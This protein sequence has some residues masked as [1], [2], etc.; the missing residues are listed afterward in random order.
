MTNTLHRFG[1][2]AD[3][4]DDY[5]IFTGF[6]TDIPELTSIFDIA[7]LASFFE[8]LGRVLLEAMVLGKPVIATRVGGIVD[9]VDDGNPTHGFPHLRSWS[10]PASAVAGSPPPHLVRDVADPHEPSGTLERLRDPTRRATGLRRADDAVER[11]P[12][13]V[14]YR[15][16]PYAP[17]LPARIP[18]AIRCAPTIW[19]ATG[20]SGIRPRTSISW[21]TRSAGKDIIFAFHPEMWAALAV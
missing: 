7:I 21:R 3:L 16:P 5:V 1:K 20:T 18:A 13:R 11:L 8:G 10:S 15:L 9:V 17:H 12:H 2:L 4:K 14:L 6:R 19:V